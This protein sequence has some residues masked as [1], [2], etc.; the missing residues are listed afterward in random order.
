MSRE[1]SP[2]HTSSTMTIALCATLSSKEGT[3][4][5]NCT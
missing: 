2:A 1:G 4:A 3:V 5:S